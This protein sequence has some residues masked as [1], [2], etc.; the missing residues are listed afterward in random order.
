MEGNGNALTPDKQLCTLTVNAVVDSDEQA[1][2]YK[3]K[4]TVAF[5]DNPDVQ[6][7]FVLR[8]SPRPP[9]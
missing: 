6:I 8:N 2:E 7:N 9:H 3:K 1:I 4:V 5:A